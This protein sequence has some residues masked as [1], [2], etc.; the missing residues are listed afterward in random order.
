MEN[1]ARAIAYL[2]YAVASADHHVD[3]I[4]RKAIHAYINAHW[5]LLADQEDPFGARALDF[6]DRMIP[7]LEANKMTSEVAYDH[8]KEIF[9]ARKSEFTKEI[10]SFIL[11]LCIRT[12]AAFNQMNK[13]EL[14]LISRLEILLKS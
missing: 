10:R 8:F 2:A 13:S 11:Q 6:V 7:A 4:E 1:V 5:Q 14:V 3:E 9:E 12:G